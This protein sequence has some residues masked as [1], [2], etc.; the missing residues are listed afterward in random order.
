M[1][2]LGIAVGAIVL[3]VVALVIGVFAAGAWYL[4]HIDKL[5]KKLRDE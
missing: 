2:E 3:L 4:H 1:I 5:C